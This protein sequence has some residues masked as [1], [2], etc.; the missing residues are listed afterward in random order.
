MS[1]LLRKSDSVSVRIRANIGGRKACGLILQMVSAV[2]DPLCF[3]VINGR[4]TKCKPDSHEIGPAIRRWSQAL[5]EAEY[6]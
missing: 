1:N 4:L 6:R 2:A 5:V 3:E